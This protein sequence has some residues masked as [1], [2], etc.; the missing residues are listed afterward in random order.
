MF[1]DLALDLNLG[2]TCR[3]V[4]LSFS[5]D[6]TILSVL[7]QANMFK[8]DNEINKAT[9]SL[10]EYCNKGITDMLWCYYL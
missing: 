8:T 1:S 3:F 2:T 5:S 6:K 4:F 7:N 9:P 10:F